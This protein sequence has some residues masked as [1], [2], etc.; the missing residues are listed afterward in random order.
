MYKQII[1]VLFLSLSLSMPAASG[2]DPAPWRNSGKTGRMDPEFVVKSFSRK[3]KAYDGASFVV[4]DK[5][6]SI[7]EWNGRLTTRNDKDAI[8]M[9]NRN[10][11]TIA[12]IIISG[13]YKLNGK[14][15]SGRPF[16][17]A[18]GTKPEF[19][20][21]RKN[22]TITYLRKYVMPDGSVS[23]FSYTL[24]SLGDSKV[25]WSC[26]LGISQEKLNS[27]QKDF[28]TGISIS[29]YNYR[30]KKIMLD[31]KEVKLQPKNVLMEK[32][33]S[34]GKNNFTRY[35]PVSGSAG[36][37]QEIT[38][39]PDDV[40]GK[41]SLELPQKFSGHYSE[42]LS[43]AAGRDVYGLTLYIH[44]F[45]RAK[46]NVIIDLGESALPEENTPPPVGGIDFYKRE[47]LH[48][49]K[50]PTRNLMPNPSFEQ[51][52]RYWNWSYGGAFY[53]Q[54]EDSTRFSIDGSDAKFGK[55]SLLLRQTRSPALLSLPLPLK[56]GKTYTVSCYAKGVKGGET[57][58][59]C[60]Q[61]MHISPKTVYTGIKKTATSF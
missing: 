57:L 30:S 35:M 32:V 36:N 49:P 5:S 42:G 45:R 20:I 8:L 17:L 47:R 43:F 23:T 1:A 14:G 26:D 44:N 25:E 13:K 29:L 61:S 11:K 28:S 9:I 39:D 46:W 48:V 10:R 55:N 52:V 16:K 18:P 6:V 34:K 38:I 3:G 54:G 59:F 58:I 15:N 53:T 31:K 21:D 2:P 4:G 12:Q 60:P 41:I 56:K 37:F 24:K 40:L 19:K 7:R 51:G 27:L 50:M 22:K 33:L